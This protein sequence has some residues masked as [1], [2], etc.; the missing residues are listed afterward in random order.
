M[1]DRPAM[2]GDGGLTF[3]PD[4]YAKTFKSWHENIRDWC[5]SRQLWW[6]HRIP[7]WS[8]ITPAADTEETIRVAALKAGE[9]MVAV[10][11]AAFRLNAELPFAY[12]ISCIC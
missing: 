6:G 5:I 4:R 11:S 10:E 1:G 2:A 12:W 3:F 8:R 7:V 9:E